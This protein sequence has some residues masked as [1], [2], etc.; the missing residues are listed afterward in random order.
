MA[1]EAEGLKARLAARIRSDGPIGV[2]AYMRA[3][4]DVYYAA[5]DPFGAKG[6]F[7][8]APEITQAFGELVGLWAASAW[9]AAGSPDPF[10]LV[11]LGPGR[12]TLMRDALRAVR[13]V[14]GFRDAARLH[15]VETSPALRE[16]QRATLSDEAAEW[17]S[18]FDD[19]PDGPLILLANEFFDALPVRQLVR[20]GAGWRER[21][22]A[23]A[24][25]TFRF[26][27]GADGTTDA[28]PPALRD[29][30]E[31][32]VFEVAP[33]RE[34]LAAAIGGRIARAGGAA[35]IVDY[36]PA[37][38]GAGETLQ[39][40]R[41]HRA[42]EVLDGPGTADLSAHVDFA[43]LARAAEGTGARAWGP[44]TQG[45]FLGALGIEA[46]AA[47]LMAAAPDQAPL[48]RSAC[49]RLIDPAEMGTLFKALALTRR[50]APCPA[51]FE[52]EHAR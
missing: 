44:V 52:S 33:E 45:A 32:A 6:D 35:L 12:G 47:R 16:A 9:Q 26:V 23:H 24:D 51:G 48:I 36:G 39:A 34:A 46:R 43:T 11:E 28:V 14:P 31:G 20:T 8:T 13:L 10:R 15:L 42:H 21:Q 5:R 17:R 18:T 4:A 37:A 38:S 27:I 49:R 1:G 29:A 40:A 3:C 2:D 19:V 50:E 30:P 25:G 22:V 7:T 41:R